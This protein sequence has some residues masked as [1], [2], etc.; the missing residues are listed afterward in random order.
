M[1]FN[2]TSI[3]LLLGL[4][5]SAATPVE[6]IEDEQYGELFSRQVSE[7][8]QKEQATAKMQ[9]MA[10]LPKCGLVCLETVISASPCAFTDAACTCHNAT[11]GAQVQSCVLR[12]C[13]VRESLSMPRRDSHLVAK[14]DS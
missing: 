4:T 10:T 5:L 14:A 1:R 6:L 8:T 11:I 12:S 13:T 9:L 7:Q 2:S 3:L